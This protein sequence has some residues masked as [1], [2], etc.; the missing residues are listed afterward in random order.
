ML[1]LLFLALSLAVRILSLL[2]A[3]LALA[4]SLPPGY[5]GAMM[6]GSTLGATAGVI[7][8]MGGSASSLRNLAH[9]PQT[10]AEAISR[11][12]SSKLT[13][14]LVIS[15]LFLG[16]A[17]LEFGWSLKAFLF[18]AA[19][20]AACAT[21]LA[22][23]VIVAFRA[24]EKN[25]AEFMVTAAANLL[26]LAVFFAVAL[27]SRDPLL[28][29]LAFL[30]S[31]LL[32]LILVLAGSAAL[33]GIAVGLGVVYPRSLFSLARRQGPWAISTNV[34]FV[35]VQIDSLMVSALLGVGAN[36]IYQSAARFMNGASQAPGIATSYWAPRIASA[37][38]L[39]GDFRRLERQGALALVLV[40]LLTGL[41][42]AL[43]G[44]TLTSRLLPHAYQQAAS[45][46]L[47]LGVLLSCRFCGSAVYLWIIGA[48]RPRISAIA[49]TAGL[50]VNILGMLLLLPTA[51]L[52]VAPL[53]LA[54]GTVTT[55]GLSLLMLNA[56][57]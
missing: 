31:R 33:A 25:R 4:H 23:L 48:N 7:A 10:A 12:A 37:R 16:G 44:P 18:G 15:P 43:A 53:V 57:P 1:D 35:N 30:A 32:L 50:A 38:L 14:L 2:A 3:T 20:V 28:I 9:A 24:L 26:A 55:M 40:G 42:F 29:A 36:G 45:L 39:G 49:E 52:A 34:A 54:A 5:F 17:A 22:D 8:D 41:V 56:R 46:W 19:F 27:L 51:G 11:V 47:P 21:S 6:L 13:V